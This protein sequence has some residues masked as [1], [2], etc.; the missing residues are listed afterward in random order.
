M[1]FPPH[2]RF[3]KSSKSSHEADSSGRQRSSVSV[4]PDAAASELVHRVIDNMENL[5]PGI[6]DLLEPSARKLSHLLASH[7]LG[8]LLRAVTW[9][10][11][12]N[13]DTGLYCAYVQLTAELVLKSLG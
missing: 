4:A 8:V 3:T 13:L 2:V 11:L 12:F 10:L 7:N 6:T 5:L 9:S 1:F